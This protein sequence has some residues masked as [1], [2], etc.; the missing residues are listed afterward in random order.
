MHAAGV[1]HAQPANTLH[2]SAQIEL[3]LLIGTSVCLDGMQ[4][5]QGHETECI[6]AV[7]LGLDL[8][9]RSKQTELKKA[10]L[11]WTVSKS[12]AGSAL[13]TPMTQVDGT[14]ELDEISFALQVTGARLVGSNGV[15]DC[16]ME[17]ESFCF[18]AAGEWR[19]EATGACESND[20]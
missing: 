20:F 9:R 1:E 6:R 2:S 19:G 3:V 8:T 12:F 18:R 7:G 17:S 14:Y 11:P 13:L 10:G 15:V 5:M 16:S 4:S